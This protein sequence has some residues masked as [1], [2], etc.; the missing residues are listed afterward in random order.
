MTD[1]NCKQ[2]T[3]P[4]VLIF[5]DRNLYQTASPINTTTFDVMGLFRQP[6]GKLAR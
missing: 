3:N 4:V 2:E 6:L 5:L 1:Y